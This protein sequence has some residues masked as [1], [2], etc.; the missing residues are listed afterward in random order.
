MKYIRITYQFYRWI[1]GVCYQEIM[2]LNVTADAV[3]ESA[4]DI[5]RCM[6]K[7]LAL[8][9]DLTIALTKKDCTVIIPTASILQIEYFD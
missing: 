2:L 7:G 1:D 3:R 8:T 6:S 5:A 9:K 4:F